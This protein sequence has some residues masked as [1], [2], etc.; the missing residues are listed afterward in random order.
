[1]IRK[2]GHDSNSGFPALLMFSLIF[3]EKSPS[4]RRGFLFME[5][6]L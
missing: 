5:L 6:E 4:F 2:I 3:P 1:M